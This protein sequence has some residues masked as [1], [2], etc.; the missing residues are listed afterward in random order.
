MS[1]LTTFD[2]S[3][4]KDLLKKY[5]KKLFDLSKRPVIDE[6]KEVVKADTTDLYI[7]RRMRIAGLDLPAQVGEDSPISIQEPKY[8]NTKDYQQVK[9]G[10]GFRISFEM[11]K[12]NKWD[13]V[14]TWTENLKGVMTTYKNKQVFRLYNSADA[15]TYA[16]GLDT[17]ALA[18]AHSCL[19]NAASTW[20]NYTTS[21]LGVT[22]LES[23]YTYFR[24]LKNDQGQYMPQVKPDKL[25]VP[26]QL[27]FKARK[28]VG[29]DKVPF[30]F[31]NTPNVIKG[32]GITP[33]VSSYLSDANNWA[34]IAFGDPDFGLF[35]ET[36]LEADLDTHDSYDDA[37]ATIVTSQMLFKYGFDD[38]RMTYF[39]I[40]A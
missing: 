36:S 16:A 30:E 31:S 2:Q 25:I 28:L 29:A 6:W 11:K 1:I 9:Y 38:G 7:N 26:P 19:D 18:Y 3:T 23:A 4:N 22:A 21:A 32:L 10:T 15:T 20:T 39:G 33:F 37:R 34:L 24:T 12:F 14:K 13:L 35:C 27:E 40:V 8:G 17:A 5:L